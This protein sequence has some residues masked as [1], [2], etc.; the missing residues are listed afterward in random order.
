MVAQAEA[1]ESARLLQLRQLREVLDWPRWCTHPRL[2]SIVAADRTAGLTALMYPSKTYFNYGSWQNCWTD[3]SDVPIQDLLQLWQLTELLDWPLWC[4]HPRLTSVVAADR[5]AELTAL[6]YPSKSYFNCGSWQNCWI[7]RSDVPIQ[8]LLR[9]ALVVFVSLAAASQ[10]A[11]LTSSHKWQ[12]DQLD[13]FLW[14]QNSFQFVA[15]LYHWQLDRLGYG[16]FPHRLYAFQQR[17]FD[18]GSI[19]L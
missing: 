9:L 15:F 17:W 10:S 2:T 19:C 8:D 1:P 11:T 16:D 13:W 4:T 7:D 18:E 6:M 14:L 5:T 12:L 3:R